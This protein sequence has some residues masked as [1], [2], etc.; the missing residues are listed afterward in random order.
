MQAACR[1]YANLQAALSSSRT[2]WTCLPLSLAVPP[3][4][5]LNI[6]IYMYMLSGT[7]VYEPRI[8]LRPQPAWSCLYFALS[9][10][11]T[12]LSVSTLSLSDLSLY[13]LSFYSRSLYP[14]SYSTL[15]SLALSAHD[16]TLA[17]ATSLVGWWV[18][19][20]EQG[21]GA[22]SAHRLTLASTPS[23]TDITPAC[24]IPTP[25]PAAPAWKEAPGRLV[26]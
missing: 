18:L 2:R 11:L 20:G 24:E 14:R 1:D 4:L 16:L 17:C 23:H 5:S 15:Y 22:S 10:T 26:T 13:S 21:G 19:S 25:H 6:Y 9:H 8:P 12:P 7:K 3:S